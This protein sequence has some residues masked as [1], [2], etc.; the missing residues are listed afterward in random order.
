MPDFDGTDFD[1]D[2]PVIVAVGETSGKSLGLEWP[3][4]SDLAGAAI[5][6]ALADS[7][8]ADKLSAAIDCVAAIRTFEDSGVSMS[9]GSPDNVPEAYAKAGGI[10]ARHFI[11]A[12]RQQL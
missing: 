3:S 11:Y 5:T 8:Y 7:D 2:A 6:A 10:S 9:T 4:P 1:A 12:Y